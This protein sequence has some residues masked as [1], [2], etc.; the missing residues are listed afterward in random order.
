[1]L[2][3]CIDYKPYS[4]SEIIEMN[5]IV[6]AQKKPISEKVEKTQVVSNDKI[7]IQKLAKLGT[8]KKLPAGSVIFNEGDFGEEMYFILMGT[9]GIKTKNNVVNVE[10][11]AG[12][13]FGEMSIVDG[14]KRSATAITKTPTVL[15]AIY[16]TNFE[17]ALITEPALAFRIIQGLVGRVRSMIHTQTNIASNEA[18]KESMKEYKEMFKVSLDELEKCGNGC[19]RTHCANYI[20]YSKSESDNF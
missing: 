7:D 4:Q 1:M 19:I 18:R 16:K 17:A 14:A 6:R 15:F 8:V 3:V 9:I 2:S 13:I 11:G 20:S 5:Q 10:L 12:E